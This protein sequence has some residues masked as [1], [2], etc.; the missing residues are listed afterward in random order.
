MFL[1]MSAWRPAWLTVLWGPDLTWPVMQVVAVW[2]FAAWKFVL[3]QHAPRRGLAVVVGAH[4]A[5]DELTRHRGTDAYSV[6][7]NGDAVKPDGQQCRPAPDYFARHG[8]K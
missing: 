1:G 6:E 7:R 2:F 8:V 4:A 3:W 5:I